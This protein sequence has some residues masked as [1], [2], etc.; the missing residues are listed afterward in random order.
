MAIGFRPQVRM[1]F[2]ADGQTTREMLLSAQEAASQLGWRTGRVTPT[3]AVFYTSVSFWS[4]EE[5][6]TVKATEQEGKVCLTSTCTSMQLLDWGKNKANL[7]KLIAHM[8]RQEH[9]HRPGKPRQSSESYTP[10][11]KNAIDTHIRK[12]F[13]RMDAILHPAEGQ[14][15]GPDI[16]LIAPTSRY[17][18][19]TLITR[20][21]GSRK[22]NMP[23]ETLPD[24]SE[25][26]LCLPSNWNPESQQPKDRWPVEWL[27][28][29]AQLP[30]EEGIWLTCGHT[31]S[32]GSPL[33]A[34]TEMN[35]WMLTAPEEREETA[36]ECTLPGGDKVAFYELIPLYREEAEYQQ[37]Y[38]LPALLDK[39]KK[40]GHVCNTHRSN[41]CAGFNPFQP[42]DNQGVRLEDEARTTLRSIL[43]PGKR[44][45]ATPVLTYINTA[46]FLLMAVSGVGIFLPD[47]LSLLQWGADFGPLTLT[48][49]WWRA[50]T[51]NFVH[52]GII[53]LLMNM[54]ALLYIGAY[55][56][57]LIGTARL[58]GAYL[59]TGLCSAGVS[60]AAHPET[61]SAGASGAIFGLY[62]IF[63]AYL[64][65]HRIEKHQRKS[66]L[67]S[68]GLFVAYNLLNGFT[69]SGID[70]AAHIGGLV[71][72]IL[73]GLG[74]VQA[75]KLQ[76]RGRSTARIAEGLLLVAF[77]FLFIELARKAPADYRDV[78]TMWDSG[79]LEKY[80][81]R[82]T[83]ASAGTEDVWTE[84]IREELGFSCSYP[85]YWYAQEEE[86]QEGRL[87]MLV[88][89][90][91]TVNIS[92]VKFESEEELEKNEG[93]LQLSMPECQP[94]PI[95]INGKNFKRITTRR[96]YP[97]V[98]GGTLNVKQTVA[99]RLDRDL[100][101][102]FVIV[103]M[104]PDKELEED[105]ERIL[106]SIRIER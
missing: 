48:G 13:G 5:K 10:E 8:Q 61:L 84:Y 20:G 53:H 93:L 70:N 45:M 18:Y 49:E 62:G 54:Y 33:H 3:E 65:F 80:V 32:E 106:Q 27:D 92:H 35:T 86:G 1:E 95:R 44:N 57:P 59:L 98:G 71:S 104:V 81:T 6:V 100:L 9:T 76:E 38:G 11:E 43:T 97:V 2:E 28:K 91:S 66:L 67:C 73:L 42:E 102:G 74:Y 26:C 50:L 22:M 51:C 78:K 36:A 63:L 83:D 96:D 30:G 90:S 58:F 87:I 60:L 68:I 17:D 19:Y 101:E 99:Y 72:G 94:E 56:E 39:M 82:D 52:I 15:N 47:G 75:D 40:A 37:A 31:V 23:D 25:F 41:T 46:V 34:G 64:L 14:N 55:L 16:I 89:G 103:M 21:A 79:E 77:L 24:R 7:K 69:H 29:C 88:N 105:A 85:T 12:H 4:W